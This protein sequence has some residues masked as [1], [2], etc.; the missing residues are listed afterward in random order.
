VPWRYG[1]KVWIGR[2]P[3]DKERFHVQAKYAD[4]QIDTPTR[5]TGVGPHAPAHS[6]ANVGYDGSSQTGLAG[7]DPVILD[8]RGLFNVGLHPYSGLQARASAWRRRVTSRRMPR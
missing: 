6:F 4:P 2:P 3:D 8:D 5:F 1:I 7:E